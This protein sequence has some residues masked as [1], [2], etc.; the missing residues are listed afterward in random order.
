MSIYGDG[1]VNRP[2]LFA[3]PR[4]ILADAGLQA[5]SL[6]KPNA[7]SEPIASCE[8][9]LVSFATSLWAALL[10]STKWPYFSTRSQGTKPLVKASIDRLTPCSS[11]PNHP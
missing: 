4:A 11:R 1:H 8:K 5:M 10:E 3:G 7:M 2:A 9:R 6:D